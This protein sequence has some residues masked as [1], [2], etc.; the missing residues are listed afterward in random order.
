[1]PPDSLTPYTFT[2]LDIDIFYFI[3]LECCV[4]LSCRRLRA[5]CI[6]PSVPVRVIVCSFTPCLYV[7][8]IRAPDFFAIFRKP[9]LPCPINRPINSFWTSIY[10][11]IDLFLL[12]LLWMALIQS[13]QTVRKDKINIPQCFWFEEFH[14][15]AFDRHLIPNLNLISCVHQGLTLLKKPIKD[16]SLFV[17]VFFGPSVRTLMANFS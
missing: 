15:C 5:I 8:N 12:L 7:W 3:A 10:N 16:C 17:S 11:T 9:L 13:W 2:S 4:N 14:Q 6:S 1:M